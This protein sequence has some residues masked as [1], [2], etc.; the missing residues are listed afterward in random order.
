MPR[1]N[2]ILADAGVPYFTADPNSV[3]AAAGGRGGG[4]H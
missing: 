2:K 3:P 1:L 4:V